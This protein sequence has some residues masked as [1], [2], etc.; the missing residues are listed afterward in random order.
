MIKLN[1]AGKMDPLPMVRDALAKGAEEIQVSSVDTAPALK[2]KQFLEGKGFSVQIQDD[3]GRLT[4]IGTHNELPAAPRGQRTAP[5]RSVPQA[6]VLAV[7]IVGPHKTNPLPDTPRRAR[8]VYLILDRVLGRGAQDEDKPSELGEILMKSFLNALTKAF[9]YPEAVI[10]MNEG[11]KL[12]LFNTSTCDHL[13]TL[14]AQGTRVLVS[15]TCVMHFGITE[16]IGVGVL[17]NMHEIIEVLNNAE[18][19]ITL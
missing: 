10:L 3:N 1:A 12:A 2:T 18:K 5:P 4:L 15:G 7:P 19:C 8:P 11:V 16:N 17:A 6:Q 14:E 13:K 9:K